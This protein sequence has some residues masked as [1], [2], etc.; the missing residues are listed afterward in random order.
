M[1][2]YLLQWEAITRAKLYWSKL[3]DFLGVASPDEPNSSLA[4][5]TSFKKKLTQDIREVSCGSIYV[6]K[7]MKYVLIQILR[8]FKK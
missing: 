3:Y 7:S 1:A 5:V 8:K 4:W 2:P 6:N